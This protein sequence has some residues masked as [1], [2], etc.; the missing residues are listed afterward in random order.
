MFEESISQNKSPCEISIILYFDYFRKE[1]LLSILNQ[2]FMFYEIFAI[3]NQTNNL[4][5]EIQ[6]Y[7][8]RI[9]F[10]K[11]PINSSINNLLNNIIQPIG[12]YIIFFNQSLNFAHENILYNLYEEAKVTNN[13]IIEMN[14]LENTAESWNKK[15]LKILNNTKS[16]YN[17]LIKKAALF[18]FFK[19]FDDD[20]NLNEDE[21]MLLLYKHS[22]NISY[23]EEFGFIFFDK[24]A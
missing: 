12:E 13:T 10:I 17:K 16:I 18:N 19:M 8:P 9:K 20:K 5:P 21:L 15:Y 22:Q 3:S 6:N 4:Q 1:S 24:K 23:L 14:I 2:K 7:D 11:S